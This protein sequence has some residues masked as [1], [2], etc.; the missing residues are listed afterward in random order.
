VPGPEAWATR[1]VVA[2]VAD[3]PEGGRLIVE[4]AGREIGI[5]KIDGQLH[6]LLNRCP[7]VGG[8][9]CEGQLL[10]V[11]NAPEP[12]R[13]S[14]DTSRFLL[15]CPW[16]NWEF[17]IKTGKSYVDPAR[18][19]ARS[20]PVKVESGT[21]IAQ[22]GELGRGRVEGP[23]RAEKVPVSVEDDY[24][25]VELR[26]ARRPVPEVAQPLVPASEG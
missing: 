13:V 21:E 10:N 26:P 9:L 14:L 2:R 20:I 23:F 24:A 16:H 7:H 17:D 19:R 3:I 8:P 18:L 1:Y 11:I 25:V 22:A 4:V 12:G 6:G 15:A 5:F